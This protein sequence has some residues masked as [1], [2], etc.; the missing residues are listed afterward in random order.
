MLRGASDSATVNFAIENALPIVTGLTGPSNGTRGDTLNFVG[1]FVDTD[2]A[3]THVESWAVTDSLGGVVASGTGS[4]FDYVSTALGNF[5]VAYTVTDSEGGV[6]SSSLSFVIDNVA[7]TGAAID[8]PSAAIPG[9]TLT[10]AGT[11]VDPDLGDTHTEA[12]TIADDLGTVVASGVGSSL[13]YA[14]SVLGTY[15]VSYTVTDAEGASDTVSTSLVVSQIAVIFDPHRGSD[16][17]FV[18]GT[19]GNDRIRVRKSRNL[20]NGIEV[21]INRVSMG[22]FDRSGGLDH[23]VIYALGGHDRVRISGRLTGL[24][25]EIYGGDGNDLLIG[26]SGDDAIFGGAGN[27][28]MIGRS[29][30]D[31]MVGGTGHDWVLGN[32]DDDILVGGSYTGADDRGAVTS[33]TSRW[34]DRSVGYTDRVADLSSGSNALNSSTV[35]DDLEWDVLL[36]L[37]G[38]DWF[39][40]NECN[41]YTDQ[42][43]YENLN[44]DETTFLNDDD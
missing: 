37:R 31:F 38:R 9:Q 40:A 13:A 28:L 15:T 7:P 23:V 8:G 35:I 1:S 29:G 41:D 26:G 18:S 24:T 22:H 25:S 5:T 19:E 43:W 27:D 4:S 20:A 3:D 2:N 42:R 44:A 14:T 12:W 10:F 21:L 39:H 34:G 17:L 33:I 30:R 6:A 11:F 36:G 16:T 32:N